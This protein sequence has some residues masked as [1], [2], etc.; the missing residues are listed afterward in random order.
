MNISDLDI[1]QIFLVNIKFGFYSLKPFTFACVTND[2]VLLGE[3]FSWSL[4]V[5]KNLD[6][7]SGQLRILFVI[8]A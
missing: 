2:S 3:A 1:S 4:L 7:L 6:I 5:I 8:Y